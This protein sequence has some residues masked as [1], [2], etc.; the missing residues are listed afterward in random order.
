MSRQPDPLPEKTCAIDRLV[1]HPR[2]V[3]AAI[4]GAKTE[5]R[6]DGVYAYPGEAFELQDVAF[7][8]TD[9]VRQRLGDMTDADARAE[10]YPDLA[11][12]RELILAMHKG[13]GWNEDA[14]VWLH[15]FR[16][17]DSE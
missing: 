13:M 2:L 10:G 16:R 17:V 9:L 12:Y 14:L 15:R 5:Q 7:V 11:S 6:R 4:S 8:C 3:E 1:R